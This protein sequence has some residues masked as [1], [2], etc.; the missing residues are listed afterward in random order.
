LSARSVAL[1]E[2]LVVPRPKLHARPLMF[3]HVVDAIPESA[4]VALQLM[5]TDVHGLVDDVRRGMQWADRPI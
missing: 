4:S 2:R 3:A 1:A 5:F